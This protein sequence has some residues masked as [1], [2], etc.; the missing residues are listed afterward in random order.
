MLIG[1]A[2]TGGLGI[3]SYIDDTSL[4][5]LELDDTYYRRATPKFAHMLQS[6]GAQLHS[7]AP[8]LH[9]CNK[10]CWDI[11]SL[12]SEKISASLKYCVVPLMRTIGKHYTGLLVQLSP[13][14]THKKSNIERLLHLGRVFSKLQ[15]AHHSSARLFVEFRHP[16]WCSAWPSLASLNAFENEANLDVVTVIT[17][18]WNHLIHC[19]GT[20]EPTEKVYGK[21][22]PPI[23][24]R[25]RYIRLHGAE[26]KYKGWYAVEEI[27]KL[28]K[29][30]A[31]N[32]VL[33][34][35]NTMWGTSKPMERCPWARKKDGCAICNA[36]RSAEA[37]RLTRRG[38]S[39]ETS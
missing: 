21:I 7:R 35:N 23:S 30:T 37:L 5:F 3:K 39:M 24:R 34:F 8:D 11:R 4:N 36:V 12:K 13:K 14:F 1:T 6:R 31:K 18:R 19:E 16:S 22:W 25:T 26:G 32:C 20:L 17:E 10:M 29:Q 28:A 38:A 9:V 15:A 27:E 2:G 33:S